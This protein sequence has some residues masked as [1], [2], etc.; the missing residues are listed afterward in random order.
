MKYTPINHPALLICKAFKH[1]NLRALVDQEGGRWHLSLSHPKRLPTWAELGEAR[2]ELLPA[3]IHLCIPHPP[4]EFWVN[5][6]PY[7][8]HLY[9]IQ[10]S[11][12]TA[13]WEQDG[14]AAR[15]FGVQGPDWA[16]GSR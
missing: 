9:E 12:L 14:R 8:L 3:E 7:C 4:K 11:Y 13:I 15:Q 16:K 6:H 2:E 5:L 1:G 10:D